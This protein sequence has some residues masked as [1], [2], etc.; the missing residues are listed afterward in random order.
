MYIVP[1]FLLCPAQEQEKCGG[2]G[3][4]GAVGRAGLR[5]GPGGGRPGRR[6]GVA[7]PGRIR[8][9][10]RAMKSAYEPIVVGL[11][12]MVQEQTATWLAGN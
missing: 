4:R 5:A 6:P 9:S 8:I 3:G 7:K 2:G 1:I 11:A 12:G 10:L